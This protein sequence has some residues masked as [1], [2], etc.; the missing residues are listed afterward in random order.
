MYYDIAFPVISPI[1]FLLANRILIEAL[2]ADDSSIQTFLPTFAIDASKRKCYGYYNVI[3]SIPIAI[4]NAKL[5]I[6]LHFL[7]SSSKFSP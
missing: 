2:D 5:L 3:I 4:F 1:L 6:N 7:M